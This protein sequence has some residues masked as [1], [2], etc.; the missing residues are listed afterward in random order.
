MIT[1]EILTDKQIKDLQELGVSIS[2]EARVSL[3]DIMHLI[4][5]KGCITK[6]ELCDK[7]VF[8]QSGYI[9]CVREDAMDAMHALLC[10][11]I[12]GEKINPEEV[13]FK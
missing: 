11:L 7:G 3:S 5:S 12:I 10:Q 8:V 13:N 9:W 6:L 2:S 1:N 4:L